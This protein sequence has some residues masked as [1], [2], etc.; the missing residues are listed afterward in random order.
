MTEIFALAVSEIF[1]GEIIFLTICAAILGATFG[2][3]L[4]VVVWRLPLGM[5]LN[6]PASHC[7]K[8]GHPLAVK[9]NIPIFG[10]IFLHG[11]CRYCKDPIS[12]R[13]PLIETICCLAAGAVAILILCLKW[14]GP[15]ETIIFWNELSEF[16]TDMRQIPEENFT[17]IADHFSLLLKKGL[18]FT[19][20]WSGMFLLE[21]TCGLISYDGHKIPK[22]LGY[23]CAIFVLITIFISGFLKGFVHADLF[24]VLKIIGIPILSLFIFAFC[25]PFVLLKKIPPE[26]RF[27]L[28]A[29][30]IP[31][32]PILP[33]IILFFLIGSI[34]FT[35]RKE[36][37]FINSTGLMICLFL[38]LIL[39]VFE[40]FRK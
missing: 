9:D 19:A 17:L 1:R 2:S 29:I 25:T 40:I 3:F 31:F 7:P 24:P 21:L 28:F 22:S 11:K 8:C 20:L 5:S 38:P 32:I 30:L 15:K 26:E 33:L 27:L 35:W 13:Y 37:R 6:R 14:T 36:N 34:Q 39:I 16:V 4:N 12:G 23:F 10:W 18:V